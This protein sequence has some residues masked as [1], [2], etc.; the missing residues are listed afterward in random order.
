MQVED[1]QLQSIVQLFWVST[2]FLHNNSFNFLG[3]QFPIFGH[4]LLHY[5]IIINFVHCSN[6]NQLVT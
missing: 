2:Y 4:I 3:P 5:Q 1:T 6:L